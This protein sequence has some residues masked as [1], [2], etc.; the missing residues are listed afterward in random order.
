M[1]PILT[2]CLGLQ[3]I[4]FWAFNLSLMIYPLFFIKN[5]IT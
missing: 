2:F 5:F 1:S 3:A 4:A